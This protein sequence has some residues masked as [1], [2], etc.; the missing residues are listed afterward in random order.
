ML[1]VGGNDMKATLARLEAV[2]KDRVPDR[3]FNYHF[4]DEDYNRLYLA[5]ERTSL[6][7]S[8]AAGLAILLACLG[9]F[10]LAAFT[11][12]QRTKEIGIRRVLGAKV[13]S[14]TFL[15]AKNF[16][17]LIGI[18]ILIAIPAAWWAGNRWLQDFA[19][20]IPV[21]LY[22]FVIT[23]FVTIL[24]AFCTVGY[25]SIKVALSNPVKSLKTE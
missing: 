14:I 10:G 18:A 1:R 11:T 9:L 13:G 16:L 24:I 3:P 12:V 21:Q 4:L 20:R 5:D 25:H 15:I 22:V 23:V 6:L 17:Q 7:F 8:V 2:W 19:F